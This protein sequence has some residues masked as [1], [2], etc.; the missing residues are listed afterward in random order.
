ML[1]TAHAP[2]ELMELGQA[3]P[4]RTF[5]QHHASIGHV[6]TDLYHRSGHQDVDLAIAEALHDRILLLALQPAVQ[7]SHLQIREHLL[8]EPLI[9]LH[10]GPSLNLV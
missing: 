8:L 2:A 3:K 1:A 6:D 10:S 4:V 7:E 5:D 9:L